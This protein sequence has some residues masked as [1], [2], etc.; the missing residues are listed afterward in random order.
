MTTF[1]TAKWQGGL[2]DGKVVAFIPE[3][4]PKAGMPEGIAVDDQGNIVT[5]WT[6][7]MSVRRFVKK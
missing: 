4:A 2:K 1:G 6:G 5:G 7:Q 3:A